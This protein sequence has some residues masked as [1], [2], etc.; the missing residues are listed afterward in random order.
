MNRNQELISF[1]RVRGESYGMEEPKLSNWVLGM[2]DEEKA[3][4]LLHSFLSQCPLSKEELCLDMGCG[5]GNLVLAL[6][7]HF[8]N[9]SGI[10]LIEE[11]GR[12]VKASLPLSGNRLWESR[13]PAVACKSFRTNHV[14][15]CV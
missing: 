9:V 6:S 8:R 2:S 15:G 5:F 10:D 4:Q 11:A 13:G 1:L 7:Q 12:V 3:I 14:Y